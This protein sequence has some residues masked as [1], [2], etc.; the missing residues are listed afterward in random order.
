MLKSRTITVSIDRP[1][2]DV[3]AY[4][5]EPANMPSWTPALGPTFKPVG[6]R[7]WTAAA[8]L[9]PRGPLTIRFCPRN[10][11][12][13]LDYEVSRPGEEPLLV[14][15]RVFANQSGCDLQFT[16][17]QRPGVSDQQLESEVEWVHT[18][19]L[20]LKALLEAWSEKR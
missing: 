17:F 2:A 7:E 19:L 12:G 15:L 18:D 9:D 8:P 4:L 14:P 1:V 13:V 10:E 6:A 11:F 5:S 3:Y 16:Y 20:T